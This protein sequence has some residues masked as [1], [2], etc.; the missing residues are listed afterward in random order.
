MRKTFLI[1]GT[2]VVLFSALAPIAYAVDWWPLVPC[3]LNEPPAGRPRLDASYYQP[4]N[5]CDLFKLFKNIIDFILFGVVPVFGTLLVVVA[6]FM[7][8]LGGANPSLYSRGRAM[9]QNVFYGIMLIAFSW[10]IVTSLLRTVL[11]DENKA[12]QWWKISCTARVP[13]VTPTPTPAAGSCTG[14][15]CSG[16]TSS[17]CG[18]VNP[19]DGCD[20]GVIGGLASDISA[21]AGTRSVCSGV[22]T[23]KLL[24][25]V[26]ANETGGRFINSNDGKS[27]GPYQLTIDTANR[28]MSAC[29]VTATIDFDWLNTRN[30]LSAQSCIA[31]EFLKTLVGPCGCDVRQLAA[32]YNGGGAQLGACETSTNCGPAAKAQGGECSMCAGQTGPTRRWECL[33]DDNEHKV[34]NKDR[35][36]NFSATRIY[37]P[38]VEFCYGVF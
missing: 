1:L 34:C 28:F 7:M 3:G 11:G 23:V 22:D 25:A 18:P 38:H 26:M 16:D 27:A 6:G 19:G 29:G 30:T 15:A 12:T 4:C 17:V 33:W 31:A 20:V 8:L 24:K 13:G 9:L 5:Q 21:G 37:A 10:L 36:G 35:A 32:G 2:V 14:V